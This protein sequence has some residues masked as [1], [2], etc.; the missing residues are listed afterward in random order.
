MLITWGLYF[1]SPI[2]ML[3]YVDGDVKKPG[4]TVSK[5]HKNYDLML[6]LQLGIR[7]FIYIANLICFSVMVC[8]ELDNSLIHHTPL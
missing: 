2:E 3:C 4:H 8:L 1:L 5:G 7:Y 6:N